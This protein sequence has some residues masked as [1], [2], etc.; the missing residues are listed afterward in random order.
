M[1]IT[2]TCE[3]ESSHQAQSAAERLRRRGYMVGFTKKAPASDPLLVAYPY[4]ATGGNTA[5]NSLMASLPPMAGNS[6]LLHV[7]E[8][9]KKPLLSVLT[10]DTQAPECRRLLTALGGRLL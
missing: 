10:D 8:K 6:I 2:V 5:G 9:P 4:G 1:S 3:F 7:P